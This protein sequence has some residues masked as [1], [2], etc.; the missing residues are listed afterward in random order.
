MLP[1]LFAQISMYDDDKVMNKHGQELCGVPPFYKGRRLI[2]I[3]SCPILLSVGIW[4]ASDVGK[5]CHISCILEGDD[6]KLEPRCWDW[7]DTLFPFSTQSG[8]ESAI[9]YRNFFR[10]IMLSSEGANEEREEDKRCR[11]YGGKTSLAEN[12]YFRYLE[13]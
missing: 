4:W 10:G 8:Q 11:G 1:L 5:N 3:L 6:R 12:P 9:I 7:R 13:Q 2:S